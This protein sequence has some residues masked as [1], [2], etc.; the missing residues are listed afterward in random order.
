MKNSIRKVLCS[1]CSEGF[2]GIDR[3]VFLDTNF[4]WSRKYLEDLGIWDDDRK[5]QA[6]Q[7]RVAIPV[8]PDAVRTLNNLL[9]KG[10]DCAESSLANIVENPE[11]IV[12]NG[13]EMEFTRISLPKSKKVW[14]FVFLLSTRQDSSRCHV[15]KF[16]QNSK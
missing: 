8:T 9:M 14:T 5:L 15:N 16:I 4:Y 7:D 10:D 6:I 12:L 2:G 11:H 3:N 1:G 13:I